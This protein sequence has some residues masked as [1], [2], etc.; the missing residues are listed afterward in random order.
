MLV[1]LAGS[2]KKVPE[3]LGFLFPTL[4]LLQNTGS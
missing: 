1:L 4:L 3:I 2:Q